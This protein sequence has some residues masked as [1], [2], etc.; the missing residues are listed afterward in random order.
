MIALVTLL[1][2]AGAIGA[3]LIGAGIPGLVALAARRRGVQIEEPPAPTA[4]LASLSR[5]FEGLAARQQ[6]RATTGGAP[7]LTD[8]L[9]RAGMKIKG[10]EWIAI[11]AGVALLLFA[12]SL[13]RFQISL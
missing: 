2:F 10:S 11:Q 13:A 6:Q 7:T 9:S 1:A 3:F 4:L 12:I 8:E 5:P